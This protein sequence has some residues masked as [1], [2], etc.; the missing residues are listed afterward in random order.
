MLP[1]VSQIIDQVPR[2]A[3]LGGNEQLIDPLQSMG[4]SASL[5]GVTEKISESTRQSESLKDSLSTSGLSS[6]KTA[7]ARERG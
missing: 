2:R 3:D 1:P 4:R 5:S 6:D 7:E